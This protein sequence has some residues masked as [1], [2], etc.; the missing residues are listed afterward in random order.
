MLKEMQQLVCVLMAL[1]GTTLSAMADSVDVKV[2]G[3]IIPSSC[4]PALSGGGVIDY[5]NIGA[6]S[7]SKTDYTL[8]SLKSLDFTVKCNAATKVAVKAIEGRPGTAAGTI[9]NGY[10][11]VGM[12][13]FFVLDNDQI[14]AGL[15]MDGE[16]RIGG[17]AIRITAGTVTADGNS[18]DSIF[19]LN[20]GSH[21]QNE[22]KRPLYNIGRMIYHSWAAAG[23]TIPLAFTN[24]SGKL[25]VKAY[26]NKASELDVSKPVR[27]DGLTTIELVYL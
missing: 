6:E 12:V 1:G 9:L 23:T 22:G 10:G 14:V 11:G 21:W 5:G 19:S 18:V 13:P 8:L 2:M 26:L 4:T 7:L 3:T 16:R 17:Y 15:G 24:L 27:L 25:E 20:E